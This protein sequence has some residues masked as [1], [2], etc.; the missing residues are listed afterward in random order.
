MAKIDWRS[1]AAKL[2]TMTEQQVKDLLDEEM[3]VHRRPVF[4]RRLHQRYASL[5]TARER[6]EIMKRVKGAKI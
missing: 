5:R 6:G 3:A 1:L 2:H 4:A